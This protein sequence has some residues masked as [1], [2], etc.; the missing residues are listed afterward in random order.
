MMANEVV[1]YTKKIKMKDACFILYVNL[2]KVYDSVSWD[3][4]D[5]MMYRMGFFFFLH[6]MERLD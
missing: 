6:K 5:Y 4:L 2:G 3:F 1:D